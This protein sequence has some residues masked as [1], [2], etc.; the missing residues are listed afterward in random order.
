MLLSR[1]LGV[2]ARYVV[3]YYGHETDSAGATIVRERDAHAWAECW[4]DGL[5]WITV[6]ATPGGGRPDQNRKPISR[7]MRFREWIQDFMSKLRASVSGANAVRLV[8][9]LLGAA[10]LGALW[11]WFRRTRSPRQPRSR[12][13]AYTASQAELTAL[14]ARFETL[15]RKLGLTRPTA[16]TWREYLNG[17]TAETTPPEFD[18]DTALTFVHAYNAA[19]F[20][21]ATPEA[22]VL[23]DE[24]LDRLAVSRTFA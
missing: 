22:F 18:R 20:G 23:L 21:V 5:G 19:R 12:D 14:L 9:A 7:L 4:I 17:L 2:P 24:A 16:L 10:L 6:D 13:F 8:P 15:C 3:G 11:H 1:C